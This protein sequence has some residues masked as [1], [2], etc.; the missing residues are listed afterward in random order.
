M[1]KK[2]TYEQRREEVLDVC[3]YEKQ[4]YEMPIP[5][6]EAYTID[7]EMVVRSYKR[8]GSPRQMNCKLN[9]HGGYE[10][11]LW[12]VDAN[13]LRQKMS[14]SPLRLYLCACSGLDSRATTL[15][16]FEYDENGLPIA[17]KMQV[18]DK[19]K[20]KPGKVITTS[21]YRKGMTDKEKQLALAA[22]SE[23]EIKALQRAVD[24]EDYKELM[25][26]MWSYKQLVVGMLYVRHFIRRQRAEELFSIA[27]EHITTRIKRDHM[28]VRNILWTLIHCALQAKL[29][30]A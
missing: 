3:H 25:E 1:I 20:R 11:N 14:F 4:L 28:V 30:K 7:A 21:A 23:Y 10:Y 6:M 15:D 29:N 5:G 13:G 19:M 8:P 16:S 9:K 24:T 2:P 17:V 26:I 22:R 18:K 27:V 12:C